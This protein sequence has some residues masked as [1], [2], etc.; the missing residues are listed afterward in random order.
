MIQN[1]VLSDVLEPMA[2][3]VVSAITLYVFGGSS[4]QKMG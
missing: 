4:L 1:A 2:T 3:L